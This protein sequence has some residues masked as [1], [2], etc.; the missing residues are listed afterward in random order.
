M[1][2]ATILATGCFHSAA[3]SGGALLAALRAG[4]RQGALLIDAGDFFGGNAFHEYTQGRVEERLLADLYDVVVPG[5]H[6][7]ADLLRLEDPQAFPPV[8]CLN[9]APPPAFTGQ[10][11]PG[12]VLDGRGRR[13]GVL[14]IMGSQAF[15]AV[16]P[17]ERAG[18]QFSEPTPALLTAERDR[19]LAAG[20]DTVLAVSHSGFLADVDLHLGGAP[21]EIIVAGHCHSEHTHWA[22]P[23]RHVVKAPE[24]G[25]GLLRIELDDAT[26]PSFTIQY[27]QGTDGRTP[28]Q[29]DY[30][31]DAITGYQEWGSESL[32]T[33][34]AAIA[35]RQQLA[36]TL[37]A[38]ARAAV[39]ADAFVLNLGAL[40]AG[41]PSQVD[42][43]ALTAAAPFDT[44]LVQLHGDH[45]LSQ[46]LDRA[47]TLGETPVA[48]SHLIG[49]LG[50]IA[51]TRYLA[52]RLDLPFTLADPEQTLRSTLTD[53]LQEC[54]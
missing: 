52:E 15:H 42:R 19:L 8:A 48:A 5:N 30:L 22:S 7:L 2:A 21:L 38:R 47:T 45:R 40:R 33:L 10:W 13:V 49:D 20:A 54:P 39:D 41:L 26:G 18:F 12:L 16:P 6:D 3:P 9:L 44:P 46:V 24:L 28:W 35:D 51:T 43:L 37:A 53:L 11:V 29:P 4:K 34:T 23:P 17:A 27:T 50:T 25:A 1:S 31:T 32:G 36:E 14:G